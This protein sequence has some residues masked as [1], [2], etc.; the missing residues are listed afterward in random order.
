VGLARFE[1]S[2]ELAYHMQEENVGDG[3]IIGCVVLD[4]KSGALIRRS[5]EN[6]QVSVT[7]FQ[8]G[9]STGL[10]QEQGLVILANLGEPKLTVGT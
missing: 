3:R 7:Q 8:K 6:S 9:E 1:R 10:R 2:V 4:L 5:A